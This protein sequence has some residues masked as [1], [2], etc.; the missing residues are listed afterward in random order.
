MYKNF[1]DVQHAQM[2]GLGINNLSRS[3]F[4]QFKE[5]NGLVQNTSRGSKTIQAVELQKQTIGFTAVL[6]MKQFLTGE[7]KLSLRQNYNYD[8]LYVGDLSTGNVFFIPAVMFKNGPVTRKSAKVG[9]P[10][11]NVEIDVM[12]CIGKGMHKTTLKMYP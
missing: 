3:V 4:S 7:R 6:N 10:A 11:T 5:L 12:D 9:F 1:S 2:R 8:G